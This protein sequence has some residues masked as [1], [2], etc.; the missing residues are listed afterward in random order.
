MDGGGVGAGDTQYTTGVGINLAGNKL[1]DPS[2]D[3]RIAITDKYF[4]RYVCIR[5]AD[6][7]ESWHCFV[8]NT[9]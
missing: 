4:I 8:M 9:R 7:V 5:I 2:C 1:P 6:V 3:N